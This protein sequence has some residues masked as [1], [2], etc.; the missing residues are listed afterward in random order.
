MIFKALPL[1][2]RVCLALTCKDQAHVY[3]RLNAE[4]NKKDYDH[5]VTK[6]PTDVH[7]LQVMARLKV[8]L[9]PA[10]RLCYLC[11]QFIKVRELDNQGQWG[12]S[13]AKVA[14]F[15]ATKTAMIE[16]PRCP[17]CVAAK[18]LETTK[19]KDT[20]KKYIALVDKFKK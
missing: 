4:T 16:G 7:R 6:R 1:A 14:G 15:K 12:G 18:Q 5:Y 13:E 9:P 20:Y 11:L 10:Y 2:D 19:H 8:D 3:D 17:L